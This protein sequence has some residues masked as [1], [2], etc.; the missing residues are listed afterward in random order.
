MLPFASPDIAAAAVTI[1]QAK[2]IKGGVTPGDAPGFPVTLSKPGSY[3][4]ASNLTVPDEYTTAIELGADHVTLDLTGYAILGVTDCSGGMTPCARSGSGIGIQTVGVRFNITIRN[5]TIQGMGYRG[6]EL[7]GDSHLIEYIHARSNGV[8]GIVIE[9]SADA[10]SS[11]VQFN[12]VQRNGEAGIRLVR[13]IARHNVAD[14]NGYV[15][16]RLFTGSAVNNV[17][18]RNGLYGMG[19]SSTASYFDNVM[20]GNGVRHVDGGTNMGRNLCGT[21]PCP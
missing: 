18:T 5:G 17:A 12:T 21:V 10:G 20:N 7:T 11:I 19:L 8:D 1:T 9:Q 15:G 13:G 14:V 3:V 6:V 16:I 2:A 4:L